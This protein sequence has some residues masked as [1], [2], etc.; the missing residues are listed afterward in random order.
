MSQ[1]PIDRDD[2]WIAKSAELLV[3]SRRSRSLLDSIPESF[4]PRNFSEGYQVQRAASALLET[5]GF[6]RQGGWKVGCTTQV[7]Q[8]Y[9]GI[10]IPTAGTMCLSTI[11]FDRHEFIIVSPRRLGVECEIAVRIGR[12]L[13]HRESDYTLE[14]VADS[15]Q[16]VMA[17]IEVVEDRYLDY[18]TLDT[19]TLVADDFFH[20]GCVLGAERQDVDVRNLGGVRASMFI[21]GIEVGT[22]IGTDILGD[23]LLVLEWLANHQAA[24]GS[25][26]RA[27]DV[28]LLGSLVQTQWVSPGDQVEVVNTSLSDV[29]A[30]FRLE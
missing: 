24:Q 13:P 16:S 9:L 25:P 12:D 18:S 8:T 28:V 5:N 4:R 29:S 22:G 23:P 3:K 14:D 19:P 15:V 30:R 27:G 26:L 20:F 2:E 11:R 6:G 17:A 21:N 10:D 1:S 7:M